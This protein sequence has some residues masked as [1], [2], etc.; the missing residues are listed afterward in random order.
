M[1][2]TR[3]I[4]GRLRRM[5]NSRI[6][7][8][9]ARS[10]KSLFGNQRTFFFRKSFFAAGG[11][12]RDSAALERSDHSRSEATRYTPKKRKGAWGETHLAFLKTKS[13]PQAFL[14]ALSRQKRIDFSGSKPLKST[15]AHIN[16]SKFLRKS[17]RL[18]QSVCVK[19]R[20]TQT[21]DFG[22]STPAKSPES[23]YKSE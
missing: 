21:R 22:G 23:A 4:F 8:R 9:R 17:R 12:R 6:C 18:S 13:F 3:R 2:G 20:F 19:L 10:E 14:E 5:S 15:R 1:R 7:F 16:R 11:T